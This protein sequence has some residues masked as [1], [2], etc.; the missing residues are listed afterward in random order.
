MPAEKVF[1]I[2]SKGLYRQE[3]PVRDPAYLRFVRSFPCHVCRKRYGIEAAHVG[4]HGIGQK[5]SDF[6]TVSLC[7]VCHAQLHSTGPQR[8]QASH[9]VDFQ[10]LTAQYQALWN[11]RK[12][13]A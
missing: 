9:G 4:P 1:G 8:F 3:P 10:E 13:A 6:Q 11:E 5:A 2:R 12:K 7:R